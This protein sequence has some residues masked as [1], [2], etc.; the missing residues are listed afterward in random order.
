M[1]SEP[2]TATVD[3]VGIMDRAR[4][5]G[6]PLFVTTLS[7]LAMIFDGFDIQII[8]FAAPSLLAEFG[9]PRAQLG[10]IL[11]AGLVGMALGAFTLGPLG[12]SKGRRF[13]LTVS[14]LL[15]AVTSAGAA[16]SAD[17]TEL[18]W[19]RLATG[20]GLGGTVPNAVAMTLEYAPLAVRNT[21][22]AMTNV[23]V[24]I[25]GM[26]GAEIAAHVIPAFG[27]R[28]LFWIGALLPALLAIVI[29]VWMPESPRYLA[30][31]GR[32]RDRLAA[33]LNR[34][35]GRNDLHAGM[36]FEVREE[37]PVNQS[38]GARALLAPAFRRD[39]LLIWLIFFTNIFAIYAFVNW[40][41]TVLSAAGLPMGIALRGSLAFNLGG[42][43][44]SFVLAVLMSRFGSRATL[45]VVAALAVAVTL[46]IAFIEVTPPD[47]GVLLL[48]GAVTLAGATILGL[49]VCMF[50]VAA[51]AYP[52][53][54]RSGGV[55]WAS[56][57]ARIGGVLSSLVGGVLLTADGETTRFFVAIA[58]VLVAAFIGVYLL[59][60]HI[61]A[62]PRAPGRQP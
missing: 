16:T 1:H 12:D 58:I 48:L 14:L 36:D 27:W 43:V 52:T 54:V 4:F 28:A 59:G 7:A 57:I 60:R 46:A 62:M 34:L 18:M 37:A 53:E 2:K 26:I 17:P 23:G 9:I 55:G 32:D 25:G 10:P 6:V 5:A 61:P 47:R 33:L 21:V 8:A 3:V 20:I 51:N 29:A 42:V 35:G 41:P 11:A 24:P 30:R 50:T 31:R 45:R 49:Q 19:W 56:G 38:A 13:A 39:T 44:A 22:V 40:M 15:I